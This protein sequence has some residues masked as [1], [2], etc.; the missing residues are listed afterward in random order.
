MITIFSIFAVSI[1]LEVFRPFFHLHLIFLS[2]YS[3]NPLNIYTNCYRDLRV[4]QDSYD[5]NIFN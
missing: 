4:L 1:L 2:H 3:C 5:I